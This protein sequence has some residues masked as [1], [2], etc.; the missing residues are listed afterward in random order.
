VLHYFAANRG[1]RY[2]AVIG[3]KAFRTFL[4]ARKNTA[5]VSVGRNL[6]ALE[7]LVENKDKQWSHFKADLFQY[8]WWQLVRTCGFT[9]VPSRFARSLQTPAAVI[10]KFSIFGNSIWQLVPYQYSQQ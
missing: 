8:S 4:V 7:T 3:S 1:E 2:G 5:M 10:T 6:A 9:T